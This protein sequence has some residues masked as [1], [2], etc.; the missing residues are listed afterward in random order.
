MADAPQQIERHVSD[1][2]DWLVDQDYRHWQAVSARL[3]T[4][5]REHGDRMLG[6]KISAA[7][8]RTGGA[9]SNRSGAKRSASSIPTIGAGIRSDRQ[10]RAHG[11]RHD[12]GGR[13]RG[14]RAGRPSV[15]RGHDGRKGRRGL[16][17]AGVISSWGSDHAGERR[18]KARAGSG[19]SHRSSPTFAPRS[20]PSSSARRTSARTASPT[21]SVPIRGS[22][23]RQ[24]ERW[25]SHRSALTRSREPHQP[26]AAPARRIA[27]IHPAAARSLS[28]LSSLSS[29]K[30]PWI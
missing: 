26:A 20:A 22:C 10:W 27:V 15:A 17:L 14:A 21:P 24:R 5:H 12:R 9:C 1:I 2:I 3:A 30:T 29:Q 18:K 4:R 11:R 8:T 23:A 16:W 28:P 7:F 19:T 6:P 25:E 13:R